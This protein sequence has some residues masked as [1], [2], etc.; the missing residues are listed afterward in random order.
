VRRGGAHLLEL[1]D[2]RFGVIAGAEAI[3]ARARGGLLVLRDDGALILSTRHGEK[4]LAADPRHHLTAVALAGAYEDALHLAVKGKLPVSALGATEVVPRV[5]LAPSA[6]VIE[7]EIDD[8]QAE[9][10][11]AF[12]RQDRAAELF[13]LCREAAL[14]LPPHHPVIEGPAPAVAPPPLHIL[15]RPLRGR[16]E[17][18]LARAAEIEEHVAVDGVEVCVSR[19]P[20]GTSIERTRIERLDGLSPRGHQRLQRLGLTRDPRFRAATGDLFEQRL[21][22]IR[23]AGIVLGAYAM[24]ELDRVEEREDLTEDSAS[25]TPDLILVGEHR[26]VTFFLRPDQTIVAHD[27]LDDSLTPLAKDPL[28]F[29]ERLLLQVDLQRRVGKGELRATSVD[30]P[31]TTAASMGIPPAPYATDELARAW[32]SDDRAIL[33]GAWGARLYTC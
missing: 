26:D 16:G 1:P 25:I 28:V 10:T 33:A 15:Y 9:V 27:A 7:G 19:W 31:V 32:E 21:G 13:D 6:L 12:A 4:A 30:D 23:G 8:P 17:G 20:S 24:R 29:F 14:V 11:H 18:W 5:W 22:G 3:G 2:R